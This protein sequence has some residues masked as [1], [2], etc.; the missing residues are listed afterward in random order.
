MSRTCNYGRIKKYIGTHK[1]KTAQFASVIDNNFTS[2]FP[3]PQ[4]S[5]TAYAA[6]NEKRC[7]DLTQ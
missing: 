2:A 5:E 1:S 3:W 7:H 4:Y 6:D